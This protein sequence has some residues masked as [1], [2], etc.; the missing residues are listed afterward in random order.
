MSGKTVRLNLRPSCRTAQNGFPRTPTTAPRTARQRKALR[1]SCGTM[2]LHCSVAFRTLMLSWR[3]R[4]LDLFHHRRTCKQQTSG[5]RLS[6]FGQSTQT[7]YDI[8]KRFTPIQKTFLMKSSWLS[9][10]R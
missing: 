6:L 3:T 10:R 9:T 8:G 1:R 5:D 2:T 4:S 7:T